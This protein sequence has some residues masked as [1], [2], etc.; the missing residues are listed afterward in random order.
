MAK[1]PTII[2]VINKDSPC[3][4]YIKHYFKNV[5]DSKIYYGSIL[6]FSSEENT[7]YV[8]ELSALG[9]MDSTIDMY[10]TAE[11][12]EINNLVKKRLFDICKFMINNK[13]LPEIIANNYYIPLGSSFIIPLS[14]GNNC[15]I[16]APIQSYRPNII[17]NSKNFY[18]FFKAILKLIKNFNNF[19]G[20]IEQIIIP[21][22]METNDDV[23]YMF[24]AYFDIF[25]NL[26]SDIP[27]FMNST[28]YYFIAPLEKNY[29]ILKRKTA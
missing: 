5:S 4:K 27:L 9:N 22:F 1:F 7:C 15:F 25:T 20:K 19:G 24:N 11:I 26:D 29:S 13:K 3:K 23:K 17:N 10:Y 8:S 18:Y 14:K 6:D 28:T 21:E 12:P 2:F 16:G